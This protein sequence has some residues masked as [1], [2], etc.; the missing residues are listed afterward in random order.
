VLFNKPFK[1]MIF[2]LD[3]TLVKLP[4]MWN[5]FDKLLVKALTEL[6]VKIPSD[7]IRQAV[8]QTGGD[9]ESV[10]R[11]WGVED[12]SEFLHRLDALDLASR[13][14]LID[15][16]TIRLYEDTDVLESLHEK[17]RLAL[18]TNTPPDIAWLEVEAFDL[19]RFF[20]YF[21]M[22]GSVEQ[23]I[24]K[25]EPE[26]FLRCLKKLETRPEESVMIGDSSSD[27]IG[28]NRVGM[29]TVLID[30]DDIETPKN[31]DPPPDLTITDLHDLLKFRSL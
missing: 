22:L 11:S 8:W 20:E 29:I 1:A 12:Y 10:I 21:V 24:A 14:E 6:E 5:Y 13:K 27:I 17:F 3:G 4:S 26:G 16:G 31:I 28:G 15:K 18:L 23:H 30:R 9:F 7:E 25:P 19:E 2:D